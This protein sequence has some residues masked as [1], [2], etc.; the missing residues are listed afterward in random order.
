MRGFKIGVTKNAQKINPDFI[1]RS[2][3]YDHIICND[4]SFDNICEYIVNNPLK[5]SDDKLNPKFS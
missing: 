2:R 4:K 3:F 1:W 5:W